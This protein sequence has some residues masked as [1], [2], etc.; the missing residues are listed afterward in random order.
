LPLGGEFEGI[1]QKILENLLQ[2][3]GVRQY[4]AAESRIECH[5]ESEL[6]RFGFMAERPG[7]RFNDIGEADFLRFDS[8]RAGFDFGQVQYVADQVKV[9]AKSTCLSVRF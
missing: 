2:S 5:A 6:A 4:G 9:R 7:D 1:G 3:L 8:N